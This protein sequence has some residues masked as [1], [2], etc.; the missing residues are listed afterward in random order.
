[1]LGAPETEPTPSTMTVTEST[2][3]TFEQLSR[4][5]YR[6][7]YDTHDRYPS[8]RHGRDEID[9]LEKSILALAYEVYINTF[10]PNADR[11]TLLSTFS[12]RGF[13]IAGQGHRTHFHRIVLATREPGHMVVCGAPH[14]ELEGAH[15]LLYD[16]VFAWRDHIKRFRGSLE[17]LELSYEGIFEWDGEFAMGTHALMLGEQPEDGTLW[18]PRDGHRMGFRSAMEFDE[19]MCA[20]QRREREANGRGR[21]GV[22]RRVERREPVRMTSSDDSVMEGWRRVL[23]E[24]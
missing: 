18:M 11:E 7:P 22:R 23:Q 20:L 15:R 6:V 9:Q 1:M 16:A 12:V 21:R 8:F 3:V 13:Q 4:S 2:P 14:A 19:Y 5:S 10:D 17:W 24:T